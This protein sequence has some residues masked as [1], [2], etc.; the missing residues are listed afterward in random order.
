MRR[1]SWSI[2]L[3]AGALVWGLSGTLVPQAEAADITIKL[4]WTSSAGETDPYAI[5]AR[6]F[7]QA[8]EAESKGRIEVQLF[9]NRALGDEKPLLEGMRLGTVEAGIITNAVVAQIEPAFQINDMPFLYPDEATAQKILDGPVG[10]KLR[11]K[12]ETKGVVLLGFMEGG[13][14]AM[15]NNVRPVS[16]PADVKGVKYRVMQNPVYIAMFSSL[17]GNAVPMAWA[18][19]FTAVQQ[20]AIDG[21]EIPPTV[22]DQNKLFEVTKFLSLTNHTYSVIELLMS[23]RA[24]DKLPNDLK[25]VVVKAAAEATKQQRAASL[26]ASQEVIAT[27]ES[28]GMKVNKVADI[29]PFR[30]SVKV[31]YEQFKPSIGPDVMDDVLKA[32][33]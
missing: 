6:A 5:G 15:I 27:L 23:K 26:K 29:A 32:V 17:G 8:V 13:F 2:L 14:R 28:K 19:T 1:H 10:D 11:K 21:L 4:G 33:K 18:E 22:I 25:P 16:T 9:P 24:F 3:A 31:V 20:G 12:L 30:E 7:K